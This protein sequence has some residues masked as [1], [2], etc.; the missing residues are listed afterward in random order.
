M[1]SVKENKEIIE[2]NVFQQGQQQVEVN[3]WPT[4]AAVGDLLSWNVC[5]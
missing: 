5:D 3:D 2:I 4:Q 1:H